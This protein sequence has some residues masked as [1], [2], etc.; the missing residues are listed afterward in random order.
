M[1]F[2]ADVGGQAADQVRKTF[3][4]ER[5]E[6][7][8]EVR[9]FADDVFGIAMAR[10]GEIDGLIEG[11]AKRW[12]LERMPAVDRNLLRVAVAELLGYPQ[13]AAAIVINEAIEVARKYST[14]DSANFLNGV[15][16]AVAKGLRK[17][18]KE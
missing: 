14:P 3:W 5:D 1:R 10:A 17:K 18:E 9:G 11:Q 6:I 13:T 12:R 15:L 4:R 7:D 2:Q 16:D 8:D